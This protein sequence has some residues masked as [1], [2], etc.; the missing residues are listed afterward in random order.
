M[1]EI[2]KAVNEL[3]ARFLTVED[4]RLTFRYAPNLALAMD[5]PEGVSRAAFLAFRAAVRAAYRAGQASTR[6]NPEEPQTAA[7]KPD[8]RTDAVDVGGCWPWTKQGPFR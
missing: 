4:H 6:E 3:S 8:W 5:V 2:E 1:S 7:H